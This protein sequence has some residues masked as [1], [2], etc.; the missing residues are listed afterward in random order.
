MKILD[1]YAAAVHSGNLS[2]EPDT[3]YSDTDVLA[4][5]GLASRKSPLACALTRLFMG[6]NWASVGLVILL[7][8][9]AWH[10]A[11]ALHIPLK[12]PHAEDM[13][14]AVLAWHRDGTCKPCGGHG[15]TIIEGTL[16]L[17]DHACQHCRGSGRRLFDREFS[18]RRLEVA[19]WLLAEV[20]REQGKAGP[21]AMARLAPRLE[22]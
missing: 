14:R 19:Q 21:E 5:F 22:L 11:Q 1:R 9:M 18:G 20:E 17:G 13:A 6:D 8:D 15:T 12:R 7:S 4:A 3:T 16:T 10:K 2:S